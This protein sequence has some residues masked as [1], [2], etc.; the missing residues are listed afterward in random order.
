MLD[1]VRHGLGRNRGCGG[2]V[3]VYGVVEVI[4]GAS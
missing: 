2:F 1:L 3:G 4:I